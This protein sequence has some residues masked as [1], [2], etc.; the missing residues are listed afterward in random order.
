MYSH[1]RIEWTRRLSQ[2]SPVTVHLEAEIDSLFWPRLRIQVILLWFEAF[3]F[4]IDG[5]R[6]GFS[7]GKLNRPVIGTRARR[8]PVSL[9]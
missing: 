4:H 2:R 3:C 5:V 8:S 7:C 1:L 9:F 6:T